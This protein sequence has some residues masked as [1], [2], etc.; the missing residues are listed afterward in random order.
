MLNYNAILDMIGKSFLLSVNHTNSM[1]VVPSNNRF[2]S[3]N[4]IDQ[5]NPYLDW[6]TENLLGY[7]K[8]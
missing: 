3:Q 7:A 4:L 6:K 1:K 8:L 2:L 5:I